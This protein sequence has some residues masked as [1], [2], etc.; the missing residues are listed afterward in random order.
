M[1]TPENGERVSILLVEDCYDNVG[2]IRQ[3]LESSNTRCR[4][5]TVGVGSSTLNYLRREVPY[6]DAPVPDL[7]LFDFSD[8]RK[9]S[10]ELLEKIRADKSI[11]SIPVALLVDAK[12]EIALNKLCANRGN[13][14]DQTMFSPIDLDSFLKA[15]N[16]IRLD[17][18]LN[19][20]K[21]I[22]S[23]GFVLVTLPKAAKGTAAVRRP[24]ARLTDAAVEQRAGA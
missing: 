14:R 22:G 12:S 10:F 24:R 13:G 21:L 11:A 20:V 19:A 8:V 18:F 3:S 2:A 1:S 16:S 9:E 6:A 23:L 7:I 4:L 15:M 17:R 5:Q